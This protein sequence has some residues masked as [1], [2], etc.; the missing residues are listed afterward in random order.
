MLVGQFVRAYLILFGQT[1]KVLG[2]CPMS[3]RNLQYACMG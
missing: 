1:Q 2:K 3:D